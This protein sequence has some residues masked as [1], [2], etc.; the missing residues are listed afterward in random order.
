MHAESFLT[1]LNC[2][3]QL[4]E[5]SRVIVFDRVAAATA[6]SADVLTKLESENVVHFMNMS[7][8]CW[9]EILCFGYLLLIKLLIFYEKKFV[10]L[11]PQFQLVICI[12]AFGTDIHC[13]N[14]SF[15]FGCSLT[16]AKKKTM[17]RKSF[18]CS[19]GTVSDHTLPWGSQSVLQ[20]EYRD[21]RTGK[22]GSFND[23]RK[24]YV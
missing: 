16:N 4:E 9:R 17:N 6:A 15:R 13:N 20:M 21:H 10:L 3:V 5:K 11:R 14:A 2:N 19:S 12:F 23:I 8:F 7:K 22:I 1:V 18:S 24:D